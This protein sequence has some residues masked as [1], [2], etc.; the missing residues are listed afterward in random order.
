M[1]KPR[2]VM[3][4]D[5]GEATVL[6]ATGTAPCDLQ[7]ALSRGAV[8]THAF[9]MAK[10]VVVILG[11]DESLSPIGSLHEPLNNPSETKDPQ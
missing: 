9:P 6:N 4:H 8:I 1:L 10:S 3:V 7:D 11:W 2:A 5:G